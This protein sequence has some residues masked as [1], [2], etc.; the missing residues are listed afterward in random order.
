MFY[1]TV[2]HLDGRTGYSTRCYGVLCFMLQFIILMAVLVIAQAV[3]GGLFLAK[4]SVVSEHAMNKLSSC[5]VAILSSRC[6]F[7][8]VGGGVL[9]V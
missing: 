9:L 5:F 7:V 8:V 1:V 2:H 3:V 4:D 6:C